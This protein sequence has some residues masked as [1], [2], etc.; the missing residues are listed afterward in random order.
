MYLMTDDSPLEGAEG[1]Q[2]EGVW[3]RGRNR[4]QVRKERGQLGHASGQLGGK[5]VI[6]ND[7]ILMVA[8][9]GGPGGARTSGAADA[10][11]SAQWSQA[12]LKTCRSCH[13]A[14]LIILLPAAT[15]PLRSPCLAALHAL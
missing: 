8:A 11:N 7:Q 13:R 3:Q 14:C 6:I 15:S 1:R 10:I 4:V 12:L 5:R 2:C 9:V